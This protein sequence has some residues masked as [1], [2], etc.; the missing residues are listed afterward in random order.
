MMN[1]EYG[2]MKQADEQVFIIFK[3][4]GSA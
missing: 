4:Y 2:V 1:S 3:I